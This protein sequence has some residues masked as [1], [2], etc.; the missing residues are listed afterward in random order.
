MITGQLKP[1]AP[2]RELYDQN[3]Q[4]VHRLADLKNEG[5]HALPGP[6]CS[7][8]RTCMNG[9][10]GGVRG[11]FFCSVGR[12]N[13]TKIAERAALCRLILWCMAPSMSMH[14]SPAQTNKQWAFFNLVALWPLGLR[15]TRYWSRYVACEGAGPTK[16]LSA[17][18]NFLNDRG[19]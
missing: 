5:R 1:P 12:G 11:P 19:S 16:R 9:I 14:A 17:L 18:A 15:T 4:K 6:R 13:K 8:M 2:V 10:F 3:F 7:L